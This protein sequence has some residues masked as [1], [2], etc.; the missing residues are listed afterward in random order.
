M[1][2]LDGKA[3]P[4]HTVL[5]RHREKEW[6]FESILLPSG[7]LPLFWLVCSCPVVL[8]EASGMLPSSPTLPLLPTEAPAQPR[9]ADGQP[10]PLPSPP[11]TFEVCLSFPPILTSA[12]SSRLLGYLEP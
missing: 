10:H 1:D 5:P 2:L 8:A 3:L 11:L 9:K 7:L 4:T 12:T 6:R